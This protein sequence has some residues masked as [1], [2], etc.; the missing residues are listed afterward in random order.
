MGIFSLKRW[1]RALKHSKTDFKI[2]IIEV[3]N[4]FNSYCDVTSQGLKKRKEIQAYNKWLNLLH[5]V[6]L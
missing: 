1:G 3:K 2:L 4:K 5:S 6:W